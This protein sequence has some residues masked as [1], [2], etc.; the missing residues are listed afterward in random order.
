MDN[1]IKI[2][3]GINCFNDSESLRRTLESING[4]IDKIYIV[5]GRYPDY[6]SQTGEQFSNDE[7]IQLAREFKCKYIQLFAEQKDKRTAYL[8]A[9]KYDFL[10]VID[11]DEYLRVL[12]WPCFLDNIHR[13]ILNMPERGRYYQYQID[14]QAE[15]DK[16]IKL[17]RLIYRPYK[18]MYVNHWTIIPETVDNRPVTSTITI[19]GITIATDD[20]CRPYGRLQYDIDY[21]WAL[22]RKEGVITEKVYL[23]NECKQNFA[24]HIVAEVNIWKDHYEMQTRQTRRGNMSKPF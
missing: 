15:P 13:Y 6:P 24:D 2:A 5:D 11:A 3:A 19:E 12:S 22:F 10:L 4:F 20:L 23:D 17:P 8:K 16:K 1:E 7:T 21:Q 14:Y 9:C 18:L